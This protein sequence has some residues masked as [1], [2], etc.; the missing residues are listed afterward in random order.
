MAAAAARAA[1][2]KTVLFMGSARNASPFWGGQKRVCDRMVAFTQA[3][4]AA[5]AEASREANKPG[6]EIEVFDPLTLPSVLSFQTL[7]G[8]PTYYATRDMSTLPD[9]LQK[10]VAAVEG[11]DAI[12]VVTPEYNHT[13]PPALTAMMNFVGCSKY[14]DKVSGSVCYSGYSTPAGGARCAVALRPFL[15]ELG[16]LPV[17]KQVIV[18][19]ASQQV[20]E[21]G[22]AQGDH[23]DG[24]TKMM[25]AMLEQL[26]WW[27]EAART[28]RNREE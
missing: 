27:A 6:F 26:Q 9:D 10:L 23:K 28:Q 19:N 5:V 22:E 8:N 18:P 15:S 20:T 24:L 11:A 7:E 4:A 14:A 25:D 17:S 13:I 2:L 16:C 21:D 3:R 1:P 12:L